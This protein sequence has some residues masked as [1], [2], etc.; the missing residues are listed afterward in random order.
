MDGEAIR[1]LTETFE[2]HAQQTDGG[3]EY[4]LARDIQYLL[5]YSK[6]DNFLKVLAKAKTACEVS[7]HSVPDHFA[8]VG[9]MVDLG[10]GSQRQIDDLMLTRYACYLVAQNGDPRKPEIAFA[11]TYFAVQTRRAELIEQMVR[12][13]PLARVRSKGDQ[14]LFNKSARM[15]RTRWK[16]PEGRSQVELSPAIIRKASAFATEITLFN[17]RRHGMTSELAISQEHITNNQAVRK[18]LLERGIRPE[19]LP[20]TE[21]VKKVERRLASEE[22][23][24]LKNPDALPHEET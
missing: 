12:N 23:K 20:P 18:T 22:K 1:N 19:S 3:V 6:W 17:A 15:A 14:V 8:D 10:S 21:D 16:V 5:G 2:T 4:W 9:K 24:T 13:E 11:Q 7:G